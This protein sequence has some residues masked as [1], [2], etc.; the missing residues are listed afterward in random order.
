MLSCSV[1][2]E[3]AEIS[4][5]LSSSTCTDIFVGSWSALFFLNRNWGGGAVNAIFSESDLFSGT[6]AQ[7]LQEI[8]WLIHLSYGITEKRALEKSKILQQGYTH[9]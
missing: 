2:K 1:F 3:L 8:M 7:D 9:F 5:G 6:P 4:R